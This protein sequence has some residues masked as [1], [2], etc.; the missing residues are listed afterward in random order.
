MSPLWKMKKVYLSEDEDL[1]EGIE[2]LPDGKQN[3][4]YEGVLVPTEVRDESITIFLDQIQGNKEKVSVRLG[5]AGMDAW[6]RVDTLLREGI[7]VLKITPPENGYGALY[8][9]PRRKGQGA[10]HVERYATRPPERER[11]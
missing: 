3:I 7:Q 4:V 1:N 8:I 11:L 10:L 2:K 9:N 5:E 6:Q